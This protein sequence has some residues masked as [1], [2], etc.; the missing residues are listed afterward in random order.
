MGVKNFNVKTGEKPKYLHI[1]V[2][3][4]SHSPKEMNLFAEHI[5]ESKPP[6]T[7]II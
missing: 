1:T 2:K 5:F 7:N 6:P 3:A 4:G